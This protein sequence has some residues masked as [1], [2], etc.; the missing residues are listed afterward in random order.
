[1]PMNFRN[2]VSAV[3]V[4]IIF[5]VVFISGCT[6]N[7]TTNPPRSAT[8]QLLLS[9]AVDHAMTNADLTIFR[10]QKVFLDA[11]YFDSYD[12]KYAIGTVR[13]ALS[14]AGALLAD[15]A[16]SA[17]VIIEVRAGALSID[18]AETFFGIPSMGV[19]VPLSGPLQ[20]PEVAFFKTSRQHSYAKIALLAYANRSKEHIYSSGSL[21]GLAHNDHHKI[22]MVSWLNTDLPEKAKP[23]KE[24]K[25]RTWPPLYTPVSTSLPST[26]S[27]T[28]PIL[29]S[30]INSVP[31]ANSNG[32]TDVPMNSM[33]V[34]GPSNTTR[35]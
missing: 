9:T 3:Y 10:D 22:L 25:Y 14:R 34:N 11:T 28:P 6:T 27:S 30:P 1:M 7:I 15:D 19:P 8:E 16:K 33:P 21:D 26:R 29:K 23:E 35:E 12:P 31:A 20:T 5:A 13:D 18:N 24:A 17:E 32:H 2:S 4:P